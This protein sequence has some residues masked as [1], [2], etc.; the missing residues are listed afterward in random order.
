MEVASEVMD[1]PVSSVTLADVL[2]TEDPMMNWALGAIAQEAHAN[3]LGGSLYVDSI[4][5]ALVIHLLRAYAS[6]SSRSA[7]N[8][9]ALSAAQARMVREY[10]DT[11]IADTLDLPTL[12]SSIGLDHAPCSFARH[13]RRYFGKPPHTYLIDRR[14][15][16][17]RRLLAQSG[18]AIKDIATE[19]GFSDQAHLTRL[20]RRTHGITP[21]AF[22]RQQQT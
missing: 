12:A 10:I 4:A 8:R 11:H 20:F 1:G 14:L 2:R 21:A 13:F 15:E 7:A 18:L 22:R 16:R 3:G 9:G 17:A 5:R 19:C 6:I